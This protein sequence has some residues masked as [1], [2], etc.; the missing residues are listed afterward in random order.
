MKKSYLM[1]CIAYLLMSLSNVSSQETFKTMFYNVLNYPDQDPNKLQYLELILEETQPDIFMICELN[2][3]E[4]ADA[5]LLTLQ[6]I[7]PNYQSAVFQ[8]NSSDDDGSN[9]ND[10]QNFIYYDS[11]KFNLEDQQIV[12]TDIRDFNHYKLKL[13]TVD[14]N[15]NPIFLEVFVAHL[16][17]SS[18]EENEAKRFNMVLQLENYLNNASN[19]FDSNSYVMLAGDLNVYNATEAAVQELL[20]TDNTVPF[21]DPANRM[22]NWHNNSSYIDVFTQSTRTNS[23][24][25]GAGGGFDDRF[26]FIFTSPSLQENSE[27][28]FIDGSYKVFGNNANTSCFNRAII[29]SD[30]AGAEYSSMTRNI[31]YNMSDHLPVIL[32]FQTSKNFLTTQEFTVTNPLKLINGNIISNQLEIQLKDT[33]LEIKELSIYNVLGQRVLTQSANNSLN[34]KIDVSMLSNGMFYVVTNNKSIKPVAFIKVD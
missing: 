27:L 31:L 22:G 21:I 7:N 34:F 9:Q 33:T 5:I 24:L 16:K 26:D 15:T 6:G 13:N 17:A 12:P 4:G 18:G 3:E 8:T 10:L 1:L 14:Q 19:G 20:D 32:E 30:C 2:N 28:E 25:G 11:T 23:D 29:S